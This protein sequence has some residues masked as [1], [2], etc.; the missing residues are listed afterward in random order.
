MNLV[1]GEV[2]GLVAIGMTAG[3]AEDPLAEQFRQRVP[4]LPG[5]PPVDQPAGKACH[6]PVQLL[7]RLE[8]TRAAIGIRVLAVE[9]CD[10]GQSFPIRR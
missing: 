3:N 10:E 2:V 1:V 9:R 4:D 6:L 8:Q 5:L 7:L